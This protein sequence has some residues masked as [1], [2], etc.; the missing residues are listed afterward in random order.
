MMVAYGV[1]IITLMR[2]YQK[3]Y[4]YRK[5]ES[6]TDAITL[7]GYVQNAKQNITAR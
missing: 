3:Q 6:K 5:K 4:R 7:T 2:K 1:I